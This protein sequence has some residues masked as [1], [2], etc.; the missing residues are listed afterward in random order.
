ML[1]QVYIIQNT[2]I[3]IKR[4]YGNG[5][6]KEELRAVITDINKEAFSKFSN[7]VGSFIFYNFR[8]S[9]LAIKD[10]KIIFILITGLS[11]ST[12]RIK[13][14][15]AKLKNKFFEYFSEIIHDSLDP[16]TIELFNPII[17]SV[18]RN[19]KPKISLV[20][21]SGVGKTTITNLI[22]AE[23]I[24]VEHIPTITGD[25]AT[26]KIGK[27]EYL[28]WDFAGQEQF[29]F[30]WNKFIQGSDAILII[31]DS[32]LKNV[33]KSKFFLELI[34]EEAPYSH[35][36]VIANKQDL[37]NALKADTIER[38]MGLKTYSIVAIDP[39]NRMKIFN[40]IADILEMSAELSPLLKPLLDR[41]GLVMEAELLLKKGQLDKTAEIFQ[42][43]SDLCIELGDDSL[44]NEFFHKSMTLKMNLNSIK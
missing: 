12:E 21:F 26:I 1:R 2:N 3:L 13:T 41:E 9:F 16:S 6:K 19:L 15:L 27:L 29:N 11:D 10:H 42:Q 40:I 20:G 14:E 22:K 43:I 5:L 30:L 23:E 8:L 36:A 33:E 31:T 28:L 24:P 38:I 4:E 34:S 39:K 17:D 37:S 32:T 25:V 7:E 44:A 18:H 35:T